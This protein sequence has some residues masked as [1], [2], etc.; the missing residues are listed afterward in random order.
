MFCATLHWERSAVYTLPIL[1]VGQ[2][3]HARA[4]HE[5]NTEEEISHFQTGKLR[6]GGVDIG[7]PLSVISS[8]VKAA[9]A[10]LYRPCS[11]NFGGFLFVLD[12]IVSCQAYQGELEHSSVNKYIYSLSVCFL[13]FQP[14]L[15]PALNYNC[16]LLQSQKTLTVAVRAR[17]GLQ[18]ILGSSQ[19]PRK[20]LMCSFPVL[21][22]FSL[23][24]V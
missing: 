13:A 21:R 15:V 19:V 2:L 23:W 5:T 10:G 22:K 4:S 7:I 14:F 1:T 16:P 20:Q 24:Y 6:Q 17:R 12:I 3:K 18:R 8:C 9:P 11:L